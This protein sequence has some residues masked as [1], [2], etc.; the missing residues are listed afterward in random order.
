MR[1]DD[2]LQFWA[3]EDDG[4]PVAVALHREWANPEVVAYFSIP[5]EPR[6]KARARVVQRNGRSHTY[7]PRETVIAERIVAT[8]FR[9]AGGRGPRAEVTFG[10]FA[11]FFCGTRQRR[12]VDNMLKMVLDGLNK[13]AWADDA[14]VTEVSGRLVRGVGKDEARTEIIVYETLTAWAGGLKQTKP[15]E[16]CGGDV[17]IYDS[18]AHTRYCSRRCAGEAKRLYG[19]ITCDVCGTKFLPRGGNNRIRCSRECDQIARTRTVRCRSCDKE[20]TAPR[21]LNRKFCSPQCT[22]AWRKGRPRHAKA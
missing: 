5:G 8:Y 12:D 19:E 1:L 20:I 14:Q 21:S 11:A 15:C 18:T 13:V 6:S 17:R 9:A 7:T 3:E 4:G 2:L 16:N 22:A 10:V